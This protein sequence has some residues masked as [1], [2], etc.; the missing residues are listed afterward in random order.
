MASIFLTGLLYA[1]SSLTRYVKKIAVQDLEYLREAIKNTHPFPFAYTSEHQF[2]SLVD[3]EIGQLKDTVEY[4]EL[5]NSIRRIVYYVHCVHS[6]VLSRRITKKEALLLSD[7][8]FPLE[9]RWL[10]NDFYVL[11]NYSN[12][13]IIQPGDKI[14]SINGI[15]MKEIAD[16]IKT[17]RSGDGPEDDFIRGLLN[18]PFQFNFLYDLH[19]PEDSN[20]HIQYLN[21]SN[22]QVNTTVQAIYE[23]MSKWEHDDSSKYIFTSHHRTIRMKKLNQG[24]MLLRMDNFDGIQALSYRK[25]F[26]MIASMNCQHLVLDLRNNYGGGMDNAN[27][28][29]SYIIDSTASFSLITPVNSKEFEYYNI[30]GMLQ[31]IAGAIYFMVLDKS[32]YSIERGNWKW[33]T[34][35]EPK[36]KYNYN[37]DL[38]ILINEHTLSA[39]SYLASQLKHRV[40][41]VLVGSPSGGGEFGNA[42]YTYTSITLPN[43]K[44]KIKIPHNW[45]DYDI[46][47]SNNHELYPNILVKPDIQDL[48]KNR[49]VVL[50]NTIRMIENKNK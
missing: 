29:M 8:F 5:R 41:A 3:K 28:F 24:I 37:G 14:V 18:L 42:G 46:S 35:I 6:N 26:Q 11:R 47:H 16:S 48:L 27:D 40:G 39:A 22:I 45:I 12:D 19:F 1:Q 43:S 21:S 9:I 44:S 36:L 10:G 15:S 20:Y 13:S 4:Y 25:I 38:Y 7:K 2:N 34:I 50:E 17:Y 33:Q 32:T 30:E 31:R 23:P 49:D